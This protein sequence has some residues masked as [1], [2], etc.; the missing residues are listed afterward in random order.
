MKHYEAAVAI[1]SYLMHDADLGITYSAKFP[2]LS[3]W[4]DAS[5]D[6]WA[7]DPSG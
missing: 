3:V 4:T 6:P 2:G 1:L 5:W 7:H